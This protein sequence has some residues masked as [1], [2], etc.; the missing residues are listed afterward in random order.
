MNIEETKQYYQSLSPD[1]LCDCAC[2]RSYMAGVRAAWPGMAAYLESLGAEIEKPWEV[3]PLDQTEEYM[4]YL[5]AQYVLLG[6]PEG[7]PEAEVH[8]VEV[9]VTDSHPMTRIEAEHFVIE[10]RCR[11]PL[12]LPRR[13]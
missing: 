13:E 5:G 3:L 12:R 8:G 7:F 1:E 2:C 10:L 11:R 6:S 4:D 9:F